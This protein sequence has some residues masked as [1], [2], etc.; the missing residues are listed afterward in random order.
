MTQK[1]HY[2]YVQILRSSLEKDSNA[3]YE[4]IRLINF[5]NDLELDKLLLWEQNLIKYACA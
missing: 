1:R 5:V 2:S 4:I 3:Q